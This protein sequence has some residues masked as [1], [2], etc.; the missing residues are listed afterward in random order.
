F[1]IWNTMMG[2]S[3]LSIAWIIQ[4]AGLV[5]AIFCMVGMGL[6]CLYSAYRVT[7]SLRFVKSRINE[8]R[9]MRGAGGGLPPKRERLIEFSD[10]CAEVLGPLGRLSAV[11]FSVIALIGTLTVFWQLMSRFAENLALF[12]YAMLHRRLNVVIS[13]GLMCAS[14]NRNI[15]HEVGF[16]ATVDN[17]W[18]HNALASHY[19]W[20]C[21]LLIIIFP[22]INI[23]SPIFFQRF[24]SLGT[25]S[26]MY[27]I[28][29]SLFNAS[30]WGINMDLT[31]RTS[32]H[33]DKPFKTSFPTM[34]GVLC[35]SFFI[36][37][38]ILTLLRFQ[39]NPKNNA[40][41][42]CI[43][44]LLVGITYCLLGF[45]LYLTFPLPKRCLADN[46]VQNFS[47]NDLMATVT[48]AFLL[49]QY[50]AL[51]PQIAFITRVQ[52]FRIISPGNDHSCVRIFIFNTVIAVICLLTAVFFPNV[53]LILRYCG[54]LSGLAYVFAL[55]SLV[56]IFGMRRLGQLTTNS[57]IVH[58]SIIAIGI[59][60]F[61]A[62]FYQD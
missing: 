5:A 8:K 23:R 1:A 45:P 20:P 2:T 9:K 27:L 3:L 58:L 62:Q 53:G 21:V 42:I 30:Q 61:V 50:T 6:L 31:N 24:A 47:P 39:K 38:C 29:Y 41:D 48:R 13:T 34:T 33:Y 11:I 49:L 43:S 26:I 40:R 10:V 22:L 59:A 17:T 55:P 18:I 56:Y 28:C 57:V 32:T 25:L 52:L 19:T 7:D 60:N 16:N 15:Y 12:C 46:F 37:N 36:H 4:K 44:F 54:A 14:G 51:F 35:L